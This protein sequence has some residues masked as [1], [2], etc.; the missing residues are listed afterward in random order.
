M[1]PILSLII[2]AL[3]V[4]LDGFAVG[5]MYGLRKIRIP[6]LSIFIISVCSGLII[7]ASM[8]IGVW[9]LRF[10][11][12]T[13]AEIIGAAILIG[14]GI[15]AILNMVIRRDDPRPLPAQ[16]H[17]PMAKPAKRMIVSIEIRTLGLVI[18]ILKRPAEA[19]VDRSGNISSA[20]AALLGIAL[21]LDAFGAG[22]GAALIGLSPTLTSIVIALVCGLFISIGLKLGHGLSGTSWIRSITVL[23]GLILIAI[24]V[25]KLL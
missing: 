18:E 7:F 23:P 16:A 14:I 13:F 8:Q 24:G 15:W 20:E 1:A 4:S 6:L 22:I 17:G 9:I 25:M 5:V 19:D 12:S 3:A 2:L 21:S 10:L 11:P